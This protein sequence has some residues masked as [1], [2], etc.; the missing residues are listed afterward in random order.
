M[1]YDPDNHA[2]MVQLRQRKVE[3]IAR[4][5]PPTEVNGPDRGELLV[6]GWGGTLGA[7]TAAV[8]GARERGLDVSHAHL[9]YLNPLPPDLGE[10]LGRFDRVL[11]PEL[12]LG[13]LSILLRSKYLIDIEPFTK[14]A[15]QPF[16]VAELQGRIEQILED[17]RPMGDNRK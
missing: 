10:L 6:L 17:N 15:G 9:R 12:N 3:G 16:K 11:L 2:E 1:V 8:K 7:I 13:Q 14:V 5:I 4:E